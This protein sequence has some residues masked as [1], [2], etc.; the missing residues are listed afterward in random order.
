[1][2]TPVII[3]VLLAAVS[4][5]DAPAQPLPAESVIDELIMAAAG[6]ISLDEAVA[7]VEKRFKARVVRAE[8]KERDGRKVYELR[9]LDDE[10]GRV[11]KVRVDAATGSLL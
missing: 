5:A 11:W 7:L 10:S 9:L 8:V 1:M 3:M 2:R 6:G 4:A